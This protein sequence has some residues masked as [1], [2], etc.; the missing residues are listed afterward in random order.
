MLRLQDGG[1][2]S[3]VWG[4]KD[5]AEGLSG[6]F[7]L[8]MIAYTPYAIFSNSIPVFDINFFSPNT[9]TEGT[10]NMGE[11]DTQIEY[12]SESSAAI[13][14]TTV[15]SWYVALRNIAIVGLMS[16]LVYVSIRILISSATGKAKYKEMLVNWL[17][18]CCLVFMMH[19]IMVFIVNFSEMLS[20]LF[21][22]NCSEVI[23]VDLP[24]DTKINGETLEVDEERGYPVWACTFTGYAR[25]IAGGFSDYD[26]MTAIEFTIIYIVLVIYTVIFTII[27]LKRVLYMAFLT[28]IAPLVA[29]TYPIDKINDGKAQGFETWLKEYVFNALLQPFHLLI[30]TI[31]V[32]F[33]MN[34]AVEHP[35]YA[36][37]ALGFLIPAEK[38][39]RKMFNFEKAQTPNAMGPLG[40]AGAGML[41]SAMGKLTHRPHKHPN[42][43]DE[44]LESKD[45]IRMKKDD[46]DTIGTF[47]NENSNIFTSDMPI[48]SGEDQSNVNGENLR[49][50]SEESAEEENSLWN[51]RNGENTG[52]ND[53]N[54]WEFADEADMLQNNERI[55]TP[56]DD[57]EENPFVNLEQEDSLFSMPHGRA[58]GNRETNS[59]NRAGNR[60]NAIPVRNSTNKKKKLKNRL[61]NAFMAVG[62]RYSRKIANA[63]PIRSIGK[64]IAYGVGAASFGI[65][66]LSAGIASGDL[67]KTAQYT[68]TAA[69]I[70]GSFSKGAVGSL[71]GET[72]KI[73]ETFEQGWYGTEYPDKVREE[74]ILEMQINP[75]NVQYLRERDTDYKQILK[76]AYPEYA[77]NGCTN[78]EDFYA[79]YQLEK[80]GAS[81]D[82]AIATY[83]LAQRTGDIRTSPDAEKKWEKKLDEEFGNTEKIKD[84]QQKQMKKIEEKY[85]REQAKAQA[86]YEAKYKEIKESRRKNK[87]E[88]YR[89]L[90][91]ERDKK[92][93]ELKNRNEKRKSNVNAM[94]TAM[95]KSALK[96]VKQFYKNK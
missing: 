41:M 93:E 6:E 87:T 26:T 58:T 57:M 84:E 2:L 31:V 60:M 25:L 70:G 44:Y 15:A 43:D 88:E 12:V 75:N 32:S 77:R 40:V 91:E 74:R 11:G 50:S 36:L 73:A 17:V 69:H 35:I 38:I 21:A 22:S 24:A 8:P 71:A 10:V 67:G 49:N 53:L 37:V 54:T 96:S 46:F 90:K 29:M 76:E 7:D 48:I 52:L 23:L 89:K 47:A 64:G 16:V 78:I 65:V 86:E 5:T 80:A 3:V 33:A 72:H 30:Y 18:A 79:A 27:Y 56:L 28:M 94:P 83:K 20:N 45:K 81:R 63:H 68:T 85:K 62:T 13:L 66:G 9:K 34:L 92:Y 1:A 39:L 42:K 55:D 4:A 19:Y 95:S 14:Q 59:V 82:S 51:T 61:G